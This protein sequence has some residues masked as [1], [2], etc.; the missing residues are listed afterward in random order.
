MAKEAKEVVFRALR[1]LNH[2]SAEEEPT[3]EDYQEALAEY[4]GFHAWLKQE[5]EG[6]MGWVA[7]SVPDQVF[8]YVAGWFAGDL[9]GVFPCSP[10]VQQ[11]VVATADLAQ[12]R[13]REMLSREPLA[14]VEANYF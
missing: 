1:R 5:F 8:P 10:E 3:A 4:E 12:V 11:R 14:T 6:N 2:I 13:L 9:V 7:D